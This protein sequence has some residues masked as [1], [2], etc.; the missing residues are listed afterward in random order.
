M[1]SLNTPLKKEVTNDEGKVDF[2][3]LPYPLQ[4]HIASYL[5]F[6]VFVDDIYEGDLLQVF[7]ISC[8]RI[9]CELT[10]RKQ[11]VYKLANAFDQMLR[12]YGDMVVGIMFEYCSR[13]HHVKD[14]VDLITQCRNLRHFLI[15]M[16]EPGT[17]NML[18]GCIKKDSFTGS[19]TVQYGGVDYWVLQFG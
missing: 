10:S 6:Y 5:Q 11:N 8:I 2:R 12:K 4:E 17:L 3:T 7:P 9:D 16:N 13:L 19:V 1:T 14:I 15:C 18:S